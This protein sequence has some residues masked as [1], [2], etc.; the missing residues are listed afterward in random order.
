MVLNKAKVPLR[1]TAKED[2]E[3]EQ[4]VA[5]GKGPVQFQD[6]VEFIEANESFDDEAEGLTGQGN[7]GRSGMEMCIEVNPE[8][9]EEMSTI[10]SSL[11]KAVKRRGRMQ[12]RAHAGE[13]E[14]DSREVDEPELR[15]EPI[16]HEDVEEAVQD[17]DVDGAEVDEEGVDEN[18]NDRDEDISEEE[19]EVDSQAYSF[20]DDEENDDEEDDSA[21]FERL[22]N[23][24]EFMAIQSR[25]ELMDDDDDDESDEVA[26]EQVAGVRRSG[27]V[28]QAPKRL[29]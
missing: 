26:Q 24:S 6:E 3:D 29:I 12:L 17:D 21:F 10:S 7:G 15:V 20:D 27:R 19:S 25:V 4:A 8:L 22:Q 1:T 16:N 5:P 14:V 23:M 11:D 28:I 13:E 2:K 18:E 9:E